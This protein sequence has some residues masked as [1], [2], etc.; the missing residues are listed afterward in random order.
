MT[1]TEHANTLECAGEQLVAITT[2]PHSPACSAGVLLI[3]GGPQYRVGS[4]RQFVHLSRELAK[5]G[6]PSMRFDCRGMG[7]AMGVQR[8]FDQLDDDVRAAADY[9]RKNVPSIDQIILWG[10]CDGASAACFYAHRD[11]HLAGLVL[12]NPWV[13]TASSEAKTYL[14]HYYLKRLFDPQFWKKLWSRQVAVGNTASNILRALRLSRSSSA[15][16]SDDRSGDLPTRMAA[17]LEHAKL[18]FLVILSGNDYVANEFDVVCQKHEAW[19]KLMSDATAERLANADHTFSTADW[20]DAVAKI[21]AT[22]VLE[23][24]SQAPSPTARTT[25]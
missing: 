8:D 7:D 3:V 20:R 22:W 12:L 11:P 23:T 6:I 21:T 1:Y 15:N 17:G 24:A 18:P 9:F 2:V 13:R 19:Q 25:S 4:H 5:E 14:K 10:L 16:A